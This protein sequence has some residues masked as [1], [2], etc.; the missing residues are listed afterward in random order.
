[1]DKTQEALKLALEA[2][3]DYRRSDDDRVSVAMGILQEA[4]VEQ[5]AQQEPVAKPYAYEYGRNNGDGT[6]SVVIEKGDLVQTAPAVYNYVR[7]R[8][9]HK[10]WPIKELFDSPPASKPWVGLTDEEIQKEFHPLHATGLQFARS[11]EAKLKEK[12]S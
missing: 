1:M 4:L 9:A 5:P 12:N 7:P 10:D 6:Y 11:I 8:K 3:R 2:L